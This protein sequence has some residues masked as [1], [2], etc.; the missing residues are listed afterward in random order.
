MTRWNLV[1]SDD[2]NRRVRSYLAR[3]GGKKGDLSRFVDRAV[4][5]AIFWETVE[6]IWER[7]RHLSAKRCRALPT[8]RWPRPV[9]IVL[10]TNILVSALISGD[11]SPG[12]VL[13]AV[14]SPGTTLITSR[15]QID[16]LQDVLARDRLQPYIRREEA[17][18]LLYHLEAVAVVV[19][20][21]PEVSLSADPDDNPILATAIAGDADLIVSGDRG[22]MLAIGSAQG[23]PI[24]TAR[25]AA[26]R[27]RA[28]KED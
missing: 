1:I 14:K 22:D 20:E 18:D 10:D 24:V 15:F 8:K 7:N 19:G 9:R 4:R 2:T 23:I 25:E 11:G 12:Q 5:Q 17:D 3:T 28:G 21:L 27:L 16:E 13:A 26:D 6:S